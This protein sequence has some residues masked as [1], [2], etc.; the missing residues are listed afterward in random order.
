MQ[1]SLR[2]HLT[3]ANVAAATALFI[4][5]GGVAFAASSSLIGS[6]GEIKACANK[7]TGELRAIKSGAKCSK[8]ETTLSWSQKGPKGDTGAAGS[9]G[10]SGA[11]GAQGQQGIQGIQGSASASAVFG[12]VQNLSTLTAGASVFTNPGD[13]AGAPDSQNVLTPNAAVTLRDLAVQNGE[14]LPANVSLKFTLSTSSSSI[15]C[16]IATGT[17]TCNSGAQTATAPPA[18]EI[19]ITIQ[20]TGT[21]TYANSPVVEFG[22][23]AT[24]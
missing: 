24:G 6:N 19:S 10:A 9:V 2:R 3:F 11:P 8:K 22:W 18:S 20:N 1:D 13:F 14:N 21:V 15:T 23:R 12:G 5:L 4:A 16:T 17:R 7:Q